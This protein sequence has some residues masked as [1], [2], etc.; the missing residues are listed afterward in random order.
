MKSLNFLLKFVFVFAL[1]NNVCCQQIVIQSIS[2]NRQTSGDQGYTLD[3]L[4]MANSSREKL[5]NINNFGLNGIYPKEIQILDLYP[6]TG[7]LNNV[8]NTPQDQIFFFGAFNKLN[9]SLNSFSSSEIN[10]L[11]DWSK[12]GGKLIIASGGTYSDYYDSNILNDA[13]G[14]EYAAKNPSNF[15]PTVQGNQTDIFNG[16]F[17]V[18]QNAN[19]GA[20]AQGYFST[21]TSNSKIL[22]T[23]SQGNT[24]LFLDCNTL[25]LVVA[26]VDAFTTLGGISSGDVLQNNQDVFWANTIV[27]MDKLQ[28]FPKMISDS[29]Q[30]VLSENYVNY[31]WYR[32]D[33]LISTTNKIVTPECGDYKVVVETNGGCKLTS[34]IIS[35]KPNSLTLLLSNDSIYIK[36]KYSEY[37]WYY[38]N[39]LI[40]NDSILIVDKCGE[41]FLKVISEKGCILYSDTLSTFPIMMPNV[42]TPNKDLINDVIKVKSF[43]CEVSDFSISIMNRWGQIVYLSNDEKQFWNG[44]FNGKNCEEGVYY[45]LIKFKGYNNEFRDYK[46]F[47]SLIR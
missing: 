27:F 43:D 9:S 33:E 7:S 22:A 14:Y 28:G 18:V 45:W 31:E 12:N 39:E 2:N 47:I 32:N 23:D 37:F 35:F 30:L 20:A 29:N 41:Y 42:F 36:D 6:T 40:S 21:L 34:E 8:A 4:M 26:D 11:Y 13:W 5:L 10:S 46:G 1:I 16:P 24:T 19:Q 15:N 17:G 25:D 38:D 3:G 44:T